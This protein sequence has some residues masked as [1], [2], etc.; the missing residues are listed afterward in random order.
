MGYHLNRL[1]EPIFMAVSK[2]LLT[3]FG[4]HHGLESCDLLSIK[5]SL[6][7]TRSGQNLRSK[8]QT[9]AAAHA[10]L[11]TYLE[12]VSLLKLNMLT[13]HTHLKLPLTALQTLTLVTVSPFLLVYSYSTWESAN[14]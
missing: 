7:K 14:K 10:K 9:K 1:D 13:P 12:R 5:T 11:N 4:I 3:E 8:K 6:I 2:P